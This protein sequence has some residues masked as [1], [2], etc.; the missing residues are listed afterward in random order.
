MR[1]NQSGMEQGHKAQASCKSMSPRPQ[2]H[3]GCSAPDSLNSPQWSCRAGLA[4]Q[5]QGQGVPYSQLRGRKIPSLV[6]GWFGSVV[7]GCRSKIHG[8][9]IRAPVGWLSKTVK[10]ENF[11]S[12]QI[13]EWGIWSVTMLNAKR[14]NVRIYMASRA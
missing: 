9:C 2:C 8:D 4:G 5:G 7:H 13:L 12:W 11:P 3:Q 6:Y 14:L 1:S 10:K